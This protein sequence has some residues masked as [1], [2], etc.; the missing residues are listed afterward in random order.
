[1]PD[2]DTG[3]TRFDAG[4]GLDMHAQA[5]GSGGLAITGA[6]TRLFGSGAQVLDSLQRISTDVCR[7]AFALSHRR[8]LAPGAIIFGLFELQSPRAPE[9]FLSSIP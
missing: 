7:N 1:M 2:G 5:V 9:A 3:F 4:N 6:Y 8:I